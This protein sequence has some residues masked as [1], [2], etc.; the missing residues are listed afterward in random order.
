MHLNQSPTGK[1]EHTEQKKKM[2]IEI[3]ILLLRKA[4]I[5]QEQSQRP[6]LYLCGEK[7]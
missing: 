6:L 2:M 1:W 4:T 7:A 3:M 5:I